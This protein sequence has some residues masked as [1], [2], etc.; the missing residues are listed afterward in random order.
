LDECYV[1]SAT[2]AL[3]NDSS[4]VGKASVL[5]LL[6]VIKTES[7][8]GDKCELLSFHHGIANSDRL[9]NYSETM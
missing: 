3:G 4:I 1:Q 5:T 9:G 7:S 6:L 2:C 8:S